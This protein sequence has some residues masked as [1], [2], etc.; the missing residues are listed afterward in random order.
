MSR[1]IVVYRLIFEPAND[2]IPLKEDGGL[3][4]KNITAVNII[5][6]EDTH[7]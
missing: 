3:D 1:D 7:E 5:G 6:I 4:W 2:P